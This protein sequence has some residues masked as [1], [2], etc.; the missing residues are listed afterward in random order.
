MKNITALLFSSAIL[1]AGCTNNQKTTEAVV[2]KA[3]VMV[4]ETVASTV[5]KFKSDGIQ[6]IYSSYEKLRDALVAT[7]FESTKKYAVELGDAIQK[8]NTNEQQASILSSIKNATAI[9]EAR[10]AFSSLTAEMETIL[11]GSLESGE[12]N[13]CFCPMANDNTGAYWLS[14]SKDIL[15]PYFGDKMLKCGSVQATIN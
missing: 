14:T 1:V 6:N 11:S 10:L 4:E 15:N 2:E 5:P 7:D 12:I 8:D 13:K 9:D 3:E